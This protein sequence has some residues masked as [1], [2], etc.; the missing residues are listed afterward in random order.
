MSRYDEL[1]NGDAI[2]EMADILDEFFETAGQPAVFSKGLEP[3]TNERVKELFKIWFE[4]N[5]EYLED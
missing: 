5:Q 2:D 1:M 3:K 4:E